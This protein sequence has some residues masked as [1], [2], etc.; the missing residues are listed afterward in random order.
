MTRPIEAR[1]ELWVS[2]KDAARLRGRHVDT[3]RSWMEAGRVRVWREPGGRVLVFL[4]DFMP[5][6][7]LPPRLPRLPRLR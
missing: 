6:Q 7:D 3:I 5:P 4:P 1:P 2:V